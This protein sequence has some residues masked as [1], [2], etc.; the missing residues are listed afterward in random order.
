MLLKLTSKVLHAHKF[1]DPVKKIF[2]EFLPTYCGV[3]QFYEEIS[4]YFRLIKWSDAWKLTFF[5]LKWSWND[6]KVKYA[7]IEV[8]KCQQKKIWGQW[9]H[10]VGVWG[11]SKNRENAQK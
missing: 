8:K 4:F 10:S 11:G 9:G 6:F 7:W 1:L 2:L 5:S 3:A